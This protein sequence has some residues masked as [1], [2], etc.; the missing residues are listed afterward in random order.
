MDGSSRTLGMRAG[1][2]VA[3][4]RRV[5]GRGAG[6]RSVW[7]FGDGEEA[8]LA[9]ATPLWNA[10]AGNQA[11]FVLEEPEMAEVAACRAADAAVVACS[12]AAVVAGV[13]G[14]ARFAVRCAVRVGALRVAAMAAP[15]AGACAQ[16]ARPAL[17]IAPVLLHA[18]TSRFRHARA[19]A[20]RSRAT[21]TRLRRRSRRPA[22]TKATTT[23]TRRPKRMLAPVESDASHHFS[24]AVARSNAQIRTTPDYAG[25]AIRRAEE[26][27]RRRSY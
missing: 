7:V 18:R 20:M 26:H 1:A 19:C 11:L 17:L 2:A 10:T 21:T 25:D 22:T 12:A 24:L 5:L 6:W 8:P 14:E 27:R 15:V 3:D 16:R 9:D 13:V 23:A 4:L